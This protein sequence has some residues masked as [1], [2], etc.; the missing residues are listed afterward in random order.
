MSHN[1]HLHMSA[2]GLFDLWSPWV[3]LITLALG[4]AYFYLTGKP[5]AGLPGYTRTSGWK[6]FC[7]ASGLLVYW[8]AEGTP[9]AYYGHAHL[10]SSHMLQQSLLYLM[11]PPLIFLGIPTWM[12]RIALG[13]KWARRLL[14]PFTQPLIAILGFN[15][16]F[17]IYHIPLVFNYVFYEPVL[18]M[19]YHLLIFLSAFLMW[20]PVFCPLPEWNRLSDLQRVAYI[21]ANGVLL[22]PACALIIFAKHLMYDPYYDAPMLIH[23]LHGL[24][25]QQMGGVVMKILQE[26]VYGSVLAYCF[27]KWYRKERREEDYPGDPESPSARAAAQT[28]EEAQAAEDLARK[29]NGGAGGMSPA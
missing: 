1:D 23:W 13:G 17:S 21:F 8:A 20:F 3:L 15:L 25:D 18:H 22:T 5:G 12:A 24:D 27:M 19:G 29:G 9:V 4:F 28:Q 26:I 16:I 6:R 2:P 14:Y 10:F 11:V 7:F